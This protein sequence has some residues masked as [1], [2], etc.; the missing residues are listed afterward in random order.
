MFRWLRAWFRSQ[1]ELALQYQRE[2][3]SRLR[4]Q[5]ELLSA[6]MWREFGD[7]PFELSEKEYR[8]LM[9]HR[10]RLGAARFDELSSLEFNIDPE[11]PRMVRQ[12]APTS[13]QPSDG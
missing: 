8:R 4:Q 1:R 11:N 2:E 5:Q 12:K 6:A 13:R 9:K 10:S 3:L 7:E